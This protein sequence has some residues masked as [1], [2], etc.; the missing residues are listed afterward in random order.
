MIH[1]SAGIKKTIFKKFWFDIPIFRSISVT[2]ISQ[3]TK[4]DI[5]G[6]T[7]CEPD[8]IEVIYFLSNSKFKKKEKVF[9]TAKPNLLQIGTAP[10]KN[11]RMLLKAILGI[12]CSLSI[13]GKIGED[14]KQ[15]LLINQIENTIYDYRLTDE[16]IEQLYVDCDVV[17]FVSILEGFGMPIIEANTIGRIIVTSNVTSMPEV[18]GNAAILVD[19]YSVESIKDGILKAINSTKEREDIIENGYENAHRF[20]P[21]NIGLEYA[22]L[23]KRI[24]K[25]YSN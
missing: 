21:K 16:E 4:D 18:A 20:L 19:P 23:Y 15:L 14:V 1:Q 24:Y 13:V 3:A 2:A 11:I 17:A 8:K 25:N 22:N 7:N 12:P 6:I 5:I 9:N 10:N